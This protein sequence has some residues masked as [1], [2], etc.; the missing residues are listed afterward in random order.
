MANWIEKCTD[1]LS[2][3]FPVLT[4]FCLKVVLAIVTFYIGRRLINWLVNH[5]KEVMEHAGI[6]RGVLQFIASLAKVV[7]YALLVFSIATRFGVTET[8]VAALLGTSGLTLGLAL[9]GGLTNLVG[10]IMILLFKPY[11][12]G[13]YI[14]VGSETSGIEGSISKIE[15]FYTTLATVDN[16]TI[17]VP[18]GTLSNSNVINVTAKDERKLEIK[19]GI[20]YES[21][22]S[23]AKKILTELL[24]EDPAIKSDK[25]MVVFVDELAESS[26]VLG[27]RAWVATEEY[28]AS[29]WRLNERIKISFDEA[30]ITIPYRQMSIHVES[31]GES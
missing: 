12:V 28:W 21:S 25:E 16:K 13:D 27:L 3:Q 24:L 9:Q 17:V 11:Q 4:G 1:F 30:G 10:G 6:D 23:D 7:L 22:I 8:S 15:M 31:V 19:V 14:K 5:V 29:K 20:S 26:V 18:N 2:E